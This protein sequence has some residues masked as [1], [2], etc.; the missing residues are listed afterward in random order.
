M[1]SQKKRVQEW[2]A[3]LSDP[4]KWTKGVLAV[5]KKGL[6]VSPSSRAAVKF[7]ALGGAYKLGLEPLT[8]DVEEKLGGDYLVRV[9]DRP[10]GRRRVLS[11]VKKVAKE[12]GYLP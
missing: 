2:I 1:K 12:M 4:G 8:R 9:N 3:L 7:C 5:N 10:N 11:A 6:Q